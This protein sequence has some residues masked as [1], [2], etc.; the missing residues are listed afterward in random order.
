MIGG[1]RIVAA[2]AMFLVLA[3]PMPSTA[4]PV[5]AQQVMTAST[6]SVYTPPACV[7]GVPFS[8]ITCTTG[9]DPWIEQFA[10]DGITAGC[11]G[12]KYCPGT[13]VT[14]DQMAVFIEKSMRGT[15]NWPPHTVLVYHHPYGETNSDLNSGTELLALVAAIPSSGPE[16]PANGH[17]WLVKLGPGQYS[18][19]SS[20]LFLPQWVSMEGSGTDET[21][22]YTATTSTAGYPGVTLVANGSNTLTRLSIYN[23]GIGTA[24]YGIQANGFLGLDG[25][26]AV[27]DGSATYEIGIYVN[28]G[29]VALRSF[30][31]AQGGPIGSGQTAY[32][33]YLNN[34]IADVYASWV[35][36]DTN[37]IYNNGGLAYM[38]NSGVSGGPLAKVSGTFRCIGNFDGNLNPLTCP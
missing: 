21:M 31:L 11:G 13:P 27:A 34:G 8:D 25:V 28:G 9:F 12:G 15:A 17:R 30:S 20:A 24:A 1:L 10:L 4:Q 26:S 6:Q 19:G 35:F 37:T 18:L 2:C 23:V 36:G 38:A 7:P 32:G 29:Q 3:C 16:V 14:R 5:P 33:I 22:V